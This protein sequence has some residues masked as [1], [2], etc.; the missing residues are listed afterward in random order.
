MAPI[1]LKGEIENLNRI[2]SLLKRDKIVKRN[3]AVVTV[4][5]IASFVG[6]MFILAVC[7]SCCNSD[8]D[9]KIRDSNNTSDNTVEQHQLQEQIHNNP[10]DYQLKNDPP[11]YNEI[12]S[13]QET[14]S[15]QM[16]ATVQR[17]P[18]SYQPA[19]RGTAR[20]NP[21][22]HDHVNHCRQ[23]ETQPHNNDTT[24][25]VIAGIG[26]GALIFL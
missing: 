12:S 22:C 11:S 7:S 5:V 24:L 17:P 9:N 19:H 15:R 10:E 6:A 4:V 25:K 18:P 21:H 20:S 1:I 13:P 3:V 23:H 14:T 2:P 26:I 8:D 16:P